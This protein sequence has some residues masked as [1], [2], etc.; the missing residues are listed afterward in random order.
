MQHNGFYYLKFYSLIILGVL[1]VGYS[2]FQA[3]KIIRGPII[4]VLSPLNGATY[5]T[6]LLEIKGA[7]RN[8]SSITLNDR[9]LYIDRSGNFI[10]ALLLIPGYNIIKLEAK[11]KFGAKTKKIIEIIYKETP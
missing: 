2:I 11:D 10:D 3:Q 7:T 4:N 5:I 8:V 6:P 9:I 1:V